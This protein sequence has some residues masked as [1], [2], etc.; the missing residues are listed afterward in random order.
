MEFKTNFLEVKKTARY[1]TFG[2]LTEKTKYF[3]FALHGS[4]MLCEQMLYKFR[5]FDPAEHFVVSP[6]GL[7]RFYDKGFAGDVVAAWM[8]SRDRLKEIDDFSYYLSLLYSKYT[9]QLPSDCKKVILGFSQ[10]GTCAFRWMHQ[11]AV[12]VDKIIAYSSWLPEDINL[13]ESKTDLSKAEIIY[14]YGEQ[15]QYLTSERLDAM[16][17]IVAANDLTIKFRPHT[18]DHRVNRENLTAIAKHY[19]ESR[20]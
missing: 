8:T 1:T 3:W 19:A 17:S 6:E 9:S 15:D 14:T 11:N 10:G 16:K 7:S 2:E 18:G 12:D 5:D 20:S 4:N 13:K